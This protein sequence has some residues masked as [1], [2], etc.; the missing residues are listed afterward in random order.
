MT[1]GI[2]IGGLCP[3]CAATV[4]AKARRIA[5]WVAMG[6]TLPLAVYVTVSLPADRNARIL[7]AAAIVAW[8]VLTGRIARRVAWE[9]MK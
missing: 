1:P 3:E 8:Y 9:W 7:A 6:T 2:A 5:R 4:A